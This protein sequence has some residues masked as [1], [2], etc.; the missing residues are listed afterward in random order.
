MPKIALVGCGRISKRHIQVLKEMPD[1]ELVAV[2]DVQEARAKETAE[3]LGL[4]YYLDA[5]DM[6][7]H[8]K[9][10]IVSVLTD[11]GSHPRIGAQLASHVPVLVIEKPM[12][13]TL[14]D[15]DHLI[16]C[17]D[18]S[19]TR[20]FVVKQNR[21]NPPVV[22]L[23][24]ALDEGRFGKIVMGTVRIRWSRPQHYYDQDAWRGTWKLDGGVLTNQASHH[25]DLLQ[26]LLGPVESVKAYVATR[27]LNIEAEDT[28]AA[29]L[30]FHSGAIGIVEATV[31]TRPKD[32]EGSLSVL[33]EKG[34]VVIGGFSVNRMQTWA[35]CEPGPRDEEAVQ[36]ITGPPD[37]YGFGHRP[38]YDD[39]L[40]CLKTGKRHMLDGLEGRKSLEI[41]NAIYESA[42]TGREVHLQYRPVGVP[43][44]RG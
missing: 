21:Y 25:I 35:F 26:W 12:A 36:S 27:V 9:P 4:P 40:E 3:P 7:Q 38:F 1:M 5:I 42:F 13:L 16:E 31:A 23:R 2:C 44:G 20:L 17:C 41:I 11:S 43:L 28:G 29:I 39:V 6:V 19:G 37:V 10:D 8:E 34:S 14:E 15:A 32:L 33:G 18:H 22:L 24:K 30:K